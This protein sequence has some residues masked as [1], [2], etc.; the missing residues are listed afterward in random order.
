MQQLNA[1]GL[2]QLADKSKI[3]TALYDQVTAV[4]KNPMRKRYANIAAALCRKWKGHEGLSLMAAQVKNAIIS[5]DY[6]IL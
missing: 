5:P 2:M 4:E 3:L 6:F 1:R